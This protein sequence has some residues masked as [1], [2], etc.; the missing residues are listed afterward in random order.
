[1]KDVHKDEKRNKSAVRIKRGERCE[2]SG[3]DSAD[4]EAVNDELGFDALK[5]RA[6]AVQIAQERARVSVH[7]YSRFF[8]PA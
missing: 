7:H 5:T 8:W 3:V 1:M 6:R 4:S 2:R